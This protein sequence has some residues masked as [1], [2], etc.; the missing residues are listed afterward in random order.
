MGET[1]TLL[2]AQFCTEIFIAKLDKVCATEEYFSA[3]NSCTVHSQASPFTFGF[4][5]LLHGQ[6]RPP[7]P[8]GTRA[9]ATRRRS[10]NSLMDNET[11]SGSH[12]P[13]QRITEI[14]NTSR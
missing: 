1:I 14:K 13:L 12:W 4:Q 10:S 2:V 6:E 3:L 5:L 8:S 11:L 7:V 9:N